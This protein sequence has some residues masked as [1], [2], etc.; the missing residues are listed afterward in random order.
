MAGPC[1]YDID[2]IDGWSFSQLDNILHAPDFFAFLAEGDP[3]PKL[4]S[5]LITLLRQPRSAAS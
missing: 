5:D 2:V 1:E 3:L 4:A